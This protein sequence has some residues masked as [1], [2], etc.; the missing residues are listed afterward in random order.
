MVKILGDRTLDEILNTRIFRIKQRT[1]PWSFDIV[2]LPGKTNFAA[3]ATSRNPSPSTTAAVHSRL[4][5]A[6][7]ALVSSLHAEMRESIALSWETI[8]SETAADPTMCKLLEVVSNGFPDKSRTEDSRIASFWIYRDALYVSDGV[9]LYNDRVVIPP[10]LRNNVLQILHAAHQGV[11]AMKSRARAIVFWP[12]LT[13]DIRATRDS[14]SSCNRSAPSQAAMPSRPTSTPFESVYADFFDY[15][16]NHYLVAGDRLSGWVE[17]FKAPSGTAQSGANG[18]IL[19]LRDMF[20]T[21]GVPED[22]SSDGGPEFT[23]ALTLKFFENWGIKH[24]VSSVAYTQS[25]GRAEVAVKKA[26]RI[27][28]DNIN[29]NGS[30]N[31]DNFLRA[32]LQARNTP[33]PDCNV[34]PAEVVFGRPIRDAFSFVNRCAK[35]RNPSVRPTWRQAWSL[36]ERAMRCRMIGNCERLDE[37]TRPLTPLRI[38]DQVLIQNQ[39]GPHPT[40]WDKSGMIVDAKPYDQYLVKVDGSGRLTTRNRRFLRTFLPASLTVSNKPQHRSIPQ[41]F[42]HPCDTVPLTTPISPPSQVTPVIIP[43]GPCPEPAEPRIET[44]PYVEPTDAEQVEEVDIIPRTATTQPATPATPPPS[45]TSAETP[46]RPR[47]NRKPKK[48]YVPETGQWD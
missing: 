34:S 19:V 14:C 44:P 23:A 18:L 43:P 28:M 7:A 27:L 13:D 11:S 25:N 8:A 26:K 3:D 40:K 32:M 2:H 39:R 22:I 12:G 21:F 5:Q 42:G 20:A 30:L 9:I 4:D 46:A 24:R 47:R 16:G 10:A 29:P 6:E 37:H 38:G 31:S 36:K 48:L 17:I 45:M 15:A 41:H 1:L 33:E 35:F